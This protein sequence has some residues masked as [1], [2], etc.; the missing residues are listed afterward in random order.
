MTADALHKEQA[1]IKNALP[2]KGCPA[3][4]GAYVDG[5]S[6]ALMES[7]YRDA[8]VYGGIVD[9]QFYS[10]HRDRAD[11]YE[12]HGID[13]RDYADDGRV[14]ARGHYW[15]SSLRPFFTGAPGHLTSA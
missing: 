11:Y 13:P 10:V 6:A 5:F 14:T 12:K 15:S 7:L 3:W 8:L 4:V 1:T 9:G 2:V